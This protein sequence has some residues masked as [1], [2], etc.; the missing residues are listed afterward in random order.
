MRSRAY[1]TTENIDRKCEAWLASLRRRAKPRHR[2]RLDP[3]RCALLVIDLV[4]YFARPGDR[5]YLPATAAIV[6][7]VADLVGAWHRLGGTVAFTRHCHEGEHDLGMLGRFFDDRIRCGMPEADLVD[8]LRPAESDIVLRKTT[9]DAFRDTE[10]EEHIR[11]R[12]C[13]QVLVTGVL[14]QMCCETTVRAAFVRGFETFVAADATA[15]TGERLHVA[16][17]ATMASCVAV[18]LS[19]REILE[20]CGPSDRKWGRSS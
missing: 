2:L 18:V 14:T 10:L 13:T 19:T 11:R 3:G 5:A 1:V 12:G 15:T 16:S 9:Y 17:L 7:R 4:N 20:I 8:S 6:P